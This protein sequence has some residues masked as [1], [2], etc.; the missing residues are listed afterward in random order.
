MV[1]LSNHRYIREV[2]FTTALMMS[3]HTVNGGRIFGSKKGFTNP[4][5]PYTLGIWDKCWAYVCGQAN[6]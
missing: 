5:D 6:K 1:E 4:K 3:P 2:L